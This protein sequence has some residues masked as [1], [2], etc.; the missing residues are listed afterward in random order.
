L[1]VNLFG[2][3]SENVEF[4]LNDTAVKNLKLGIKSEN[5]GLRENSIKF[6]G[7]YLVEESAATLLE[8]LATEK[9][10]CLR[11]AIVKALYLI[12]NYKFINEIKSLA[13]TDSDGQ[14]RKFASN[15]YSMMKLEESL[16]LANLNK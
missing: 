7:I 6:A 15:L 2:Q 12:D 8:Q 13:V 3:G 14:V 4:N 16:K 1:S 11:I 9:D 5:T 10:P